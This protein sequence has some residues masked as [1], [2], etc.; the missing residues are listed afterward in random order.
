MKALNLRPSPL[1]GELLLQIQLAQ[2]EGKISTIED[3]IA[4]AAK[5]LDIP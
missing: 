1:I 4:F 2:I 5:R 3:A